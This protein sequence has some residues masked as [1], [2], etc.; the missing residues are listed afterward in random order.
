MF[1]RK[2]KYCYLSWRK[3]EQCHKDKICNVMLLPSS[4][5]VLYLVKIMPNTLCDI[6]REMAKE[7]P[8]W[9]CQDSCSSLV[10]M[11]FFV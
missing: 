1:A 9:N 5:Q 11:A 10:Q 6:K 7:N 2:L 3:N 4:I 8:D